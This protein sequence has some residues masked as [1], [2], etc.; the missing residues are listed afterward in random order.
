MEKFP[1]KSNHWHRR[2]Y[3][4]IGLILLQSTYHSRL[5]LSFEIMSGKRGLI[6]D[7]RTVFFQSTCKY[8]PIGKVFHYNKEKK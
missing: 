7:V 2:C 6:S 3:E 4:T 1:I 8:F 5:T